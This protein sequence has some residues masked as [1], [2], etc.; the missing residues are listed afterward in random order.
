MASSFERTMNTA[1]SEQNQA[2][3]LN[4]AEN[5]TLLT[6]IMDRMTSHTIAGQN[7]YAANNDELVSLHENFLQIPHTELSSISN[8]EHNVRQRT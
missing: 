5:F 6:S 7:A 2:N 4:P 8:N 1:H 3:M